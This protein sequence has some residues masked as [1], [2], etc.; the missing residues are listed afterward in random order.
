[1]RN[2]DSELRGRAAYRATGAPMRNG[3]MMALEART[4]PLPYDAH[5]EKFTIW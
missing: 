1:M 2:L 4:T 3:T 5:A